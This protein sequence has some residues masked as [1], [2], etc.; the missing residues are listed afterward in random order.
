MAFDCHKRK[1]VALATPFVSEI[2]RSLFSCRPV[3]N[4][5]AHRT[6]C[7][8]F[9]GVVAGGEGVVA[10][11]EVC[12]AGGEDG[13]VVTLSSLIMANAA[14]TTTTAATAAPISRFLLLFIFTLH[15]WR[16]YS[17]TKPAT[18][19][20]MAIPSRQRN[21]CGAQWFRAGCSPPRTPG[22]SRPT[23]TLCTVARSTEQR[24]RWPVVSGAARH[25][26][27]LSRL[28]PSLLLCKLRSAARA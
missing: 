22:T 6:D 3:Q 8:H 9:G 13:V 2:R 19:L 20:E 28:N 12:V 23:V 4:E 11:G 26:P 21:A 16:P 10:G 5:A 18:V 25:R 17:L 1:G 7:N 14:M 24:Q 27:A 15:Q